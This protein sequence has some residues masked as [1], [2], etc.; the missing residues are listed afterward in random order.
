MPGTL[1][2]GTRYVR[3]VVVGDRQF[4]DV[5]GDLPGESAGRVA[6]AVPRVAVIAQPDPFRGQRGPR[7]GEVVAP[8]PEAHGTSG[9]RQRDPPRVVQGGGPRRLEAARARVDAQFP[10]LPADPEAGR[11]QHWPLRGEDLLG[12]RRGQ[13]PEHHERVGHG[14]Q[15]E[16]RDRERA[17]LPGAGQRSRPGPEVGLRILHSQ[18]SRFPPHIPFPGE[19]GCVQPATA[20][21]GIH[22][23]SRM[24]E[25]PASRG[26]AR[27]DGA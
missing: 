8:E 1:A 6:V 9:D 3:P 17:A 7:D 14:L 4:R 22:G 5:L 13:Q 16:P 11:L 2:A 19:A 25:R 27:C 18:Q 15:A 12:P 21:A 26:K 10:D 24:T 20:P 23:D